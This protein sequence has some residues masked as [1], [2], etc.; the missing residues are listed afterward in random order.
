[1]PND[2]VGHRAHEQ[3]PEASQPTGADDQKVSALRSLAQLVGCVSDQ[4]D[5]LHI[6]IVHSEI[7][8]RPVDQLKT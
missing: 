6:E 4:R 7:A 1:M 8:E 2:L 5:P 3:S